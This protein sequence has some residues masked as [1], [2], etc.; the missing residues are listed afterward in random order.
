[1]M[2]PQDPISSL[3]PVPPIV[4]DASFEKGKKEHEDHSSMKT[5][6]AAK[7]YEVFGA[8]AEAKSSNS[9]RTVYEFDEDEARYL[10]RNPTKGESKGD[11]ILAYRLHII[12]KEGFRWLG[13]RD[14]EIRNVDPGQAD[15]M[16]RN[17]QCEEAGVEV[18]K[19]TAE[20]AK[21]FAGNEEYSV[22]EET[23]FE[24][25]EGQWCLLSLHQ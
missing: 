17:E 7:I 23:I 13:E 19:V 16:N 5:N 3:N 9:M 12:K 8:Q 2:Y 24:D 21:Y 18:E 1:M 15:F 6:L 4:T 25:E 22:V 11:T 14:L 10:E 20:D